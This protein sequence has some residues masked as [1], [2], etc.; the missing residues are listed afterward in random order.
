MLKNMIGTICLILS[1]SCAHAQ[2]TDELINYSHQFQPNQPE[3]FSNPFFWSVTIQ[4]HA[5]FN[6][7]QARFR[8]TVKDKSG[9]VNGQ[10]VKKGQVVYLTVS[11]GQKINLS[12][13]GWATVE[14]TNMSNMPVT[15]TCQI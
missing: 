1:L 12:A 15:V 10:H 6:N 7:A 14:I 9:D 3:K 8:A 5:K 13:S 11:N 4:C 2:N